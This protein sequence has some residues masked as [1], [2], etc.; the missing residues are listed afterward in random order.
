MCIEYAETRTANSG[1]ELFRW[2]FVFSLRTGENLVV[3]QSAYNH[4]TKEEQKIRYHRAIFSTT[5]LSYP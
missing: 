3:A 5:L 2:V 1:A 4:V